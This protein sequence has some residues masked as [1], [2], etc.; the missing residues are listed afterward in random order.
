M[1][2]LPPTPTAYALLGIHPSAPAELADSAY[3][4]SVIAL[5]KQRAADRDADSAVHALT[6]AFAILSDAQRR[7]D[8]NLTIGYQG[9]PLISRRTL[10]LRQSLF[11]R[12]LRRGSET[13]PVIDYYEVMGLDDSAPGDW[14][15]D[16]RRIM[17]DHYLKAPDD[18]RRAVLLSLLDEACSVISD[19]PKRAQ[20]DAKRRREA[21]HLRLRS[22]ANSDSPGTLGG[23]RG[24]SGFAR[25]H[26]FV[27]TIHGSLA[28]TRAQLPKS[29]A[30]IAPQARTRENGRPARI[31]AAGDGSRQKQQPAARSE[32][33]RQP[34]PAAAPGLRLPPRRRPLLSSVVNLAG[35][36]M[37]RSGR[38]VVVLGR[39]GAAQIRA[40]SAFAAKAL[41][42]RPSKD[43]SVQPVPQ[44]PQ[45]QPKKSVAAS[46]KDVESIL[47]G[48]LESTVRSEPGSKSPDEPA[49]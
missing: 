42:S 29:P 47:L 19:V 8:Y 37:T 5:Q 21:Q 12:I 9:E 34:G 43:A 7:A 11:S 48:R 20:Y 33:N 35:P 14:A 49:G 38:A 18:R 40:T 39:A 17:R 32:T 28:W 26:R 2:R 4:W 30:R 24:R 6:S 36:T 41:R 13:A 3:W 45:Q 16:A 22:N 31:A 27:Q 25:R 23:A 1:G 46:P 44:A 15:P 10:Q